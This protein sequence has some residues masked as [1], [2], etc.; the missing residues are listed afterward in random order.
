MEK[1]YFVGGQQAIRKQFASAINMTPKYAKETKQKVAALK[2]CVVS[3]RMRGLCD[4]I[5][6]TCDEIT[7]TSKRCSKPPMTIL[8]KRLEQAEG[9]LVRA[10]ESDEKQASDKYLLQYGDYVGDVCQSYKDHSLWNPNFR[11]TFWTSI[12]KRY[13]TETA[14]MKAYNLEQGR[15]KFGFK[16]KS[17]LP[18]PECLMK[19]NIEKVAKAMKIPIEEMLWNIRFYAARNKLAHSSV[20]EFKKKKLWAYVAAQLVEDHMSIG[21]E[22]PQDMVRPLKQALKRFRELHYVYIKLTPSDSDNSRYFV[23]K[24]KTIEEE[25]EDKKKEAEAKAEIRKAIAEQMRLKKEAKK[26]ASTQFKS[27]QDSG[28]GSDGFNG[29]DDLSSVFGTDED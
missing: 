12:I 8:Y 23:Q 19:E 5:H 22:V 27:S 6:D 13:D 1:C 26:A 11:L 17:V 16:P 28:V 24:F 18:N 15:M 9:A 4:L 14:E 21:T 10:L 25:K 20:F 29:L 3:G 7:T 2:G